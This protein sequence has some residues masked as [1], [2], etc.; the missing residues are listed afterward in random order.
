MKNLTCK[1]IKITT[2]S[3]FCY[4]FLY[5]NL[6]FTSL[7]SPRIISGTVCNYFV[8]MTLFLLVETVVWLH[9]RDRLSYD[10]A[11]MAIARHPPQALRG[12]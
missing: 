1:G 10:I 2:Q 11:I 4:F 6:F 8:H 7:I 9:F 5:V 3:F 12:L